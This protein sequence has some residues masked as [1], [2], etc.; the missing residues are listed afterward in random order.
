MQD[1]H[2]LYDLAALGMSQLSTYRNGTARAAEELAR[3]LCRLPGCTLLPMAT[4]FQGAVEEY[5]RRRLSELTLEHR[6]WQTSLSRWL[7][8]HLYSVSFMHT[9]PQRHR[10][11]VRAGQLA[12]KGALAPFRP[13]LRRVDT[14]TLRR[15]DVYHAPSGVVPAQVR[16]AQDRPLPIFVTVHDLIPIKHPEFF[17]AGFVN[18][19]KL[20]AAF[21]KD[22]W[23]LCSSE[24]TRADLLETGRCDPARVFVT[25]LAADAAFRPRP[26]ASPAIRAKYS[27]GDA[28]FVLTVCTLE[29]RK[30][31]DTVIRV[32]LRLI[33]EED[34][35]LPEGLKLVLVGTLGWMFEKIQGAYADAGSARDRIVFAGHVPEDDLPV[36]YSHALAFVYP[37]FY[38][39]FGLPVLEALQCGAP[40]ITSNTSSLPEVV[41]DAGIAQDPRD[42]DALAQHL[43]TLCNDAQ[44]RAD[45]SRRALAQ[46][47]SFSWERCAEATLTS[48]RTALTAFG[49]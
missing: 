6:P 30:N 40:V 16:A 49:R 38:E 29:P 10:W 34:R 3:A 11:D 37:S 36:L 12:V 15:A 43:Q 22:R 23:Y 39:G 47:A 26:E 41:G 33:R 48:Y 14:T 44:L 13:R 31:L 35:R 25:P 7:Y 21:T 8:R 1:V 17:P 46:A 28:P 18:R 9:V 45:L 42:E 4:D 5:A 24:N 20:L 19:E 2:V 32:F 27:L